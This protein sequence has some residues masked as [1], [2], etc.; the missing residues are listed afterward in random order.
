MERYYQAFD[1][2]VFPST[3]E[4]LPGS[5]VE[6]QA[7]GLSCLVSDQ[8]TRETELTELVTYKSI[9]EPAAN[10]A[11]EIM[12]NAKAALQ[13]SDMQAAIAGRDFDVREQAVKMEAF[14]VT[15]KNPPGAVTRVPDKGE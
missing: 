13:R 4:G 7:S 5:V 15:G 14:Y 11:A 2:F 6:A 9:G 1:Y 12:R 10:W 3:F 8:V